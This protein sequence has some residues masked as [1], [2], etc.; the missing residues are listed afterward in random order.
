MTELLPCLCGACWHFI[1]E[2]PALV[3]G[4]CGCSNAQTNIADR[5]GAPCKHFSLTRPC[6]PACSVGEKCFHDSLGSGS[7][8]GREANGQRSGGSAG[9]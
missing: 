9:H 4:L 7:A 3:A 6:S 8:A 5:F 2:W 1:D